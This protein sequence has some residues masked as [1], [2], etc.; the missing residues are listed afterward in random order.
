[1]R[2]PAAS[3]KTVSLMLEQ[4]TVVNLNVTQAYMSIIG[5]PGV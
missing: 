1:M 4:N 5:F 3:S 2:V